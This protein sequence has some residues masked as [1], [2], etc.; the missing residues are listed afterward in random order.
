VAYQGLE[1]HKIHVVIRIAVVEDGPH[2][3][4]DDFLEVWPRSTHPIARRGEIVVDATIV[5]LECTKA[6]GSSRYGSIAGG[7]GSGALAST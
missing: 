4:V 2:A 5:M 3:S 7:N 1:S 6:A